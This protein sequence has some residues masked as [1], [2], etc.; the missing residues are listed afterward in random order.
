MAR[1][2]HDREDL[3]AEATALVERVELAVAGQAVPVVLGVRRDG[4]LSVYFGAEPA[5]HFNSQGELRRAY[6]DGKLL[7]AEA[8]RLVALSRVRTAAEVQ[9][10]RHELSTE[11]HAAVL[12]SLQSRLTNL[13]SALASGNCRVLRQVPDDLPA[14]DRAQ[15]WLEPLMAGIAIAAAPHAR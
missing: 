2:E 4:C 3:L 7:K 15:Q 6:L 10:V 5:Y 9:L 13:W 11:E 1:H 12:Q 14:L 8:R